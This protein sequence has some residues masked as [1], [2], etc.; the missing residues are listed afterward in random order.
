MAPEWLPGAGSASGSAAGAPGVASAM[1]STESAMLRIG[2]PKSGRSI[3]A[4]SSPA[5]QKIC[6][7]VKSDISPSTA[8]NSNCSFWD[9]CAKRSGSTISAYATI[10]WDGPLYGRV[11]DSSIFDGAYFKLQVKKSQSGTDPVKR[12]KNYHGIEAKLENSDSNA[13][14]NNSYTTPVLSYKIGSSKGLAD[15]ELYLD[16]NNDGKGYWKHQFSASPRV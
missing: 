5:T 13:N 11:D 6:M 3:R 2:V 14:Y 9:L 12:S 10:S 4:S 1:R 16:W 15:G 7:W 8:T